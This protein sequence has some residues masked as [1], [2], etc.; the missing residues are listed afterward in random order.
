MNKAVY[1]LR[2][3]VAELRRRRAIR[4]AVVYAGTAFV[5]LQLGEILVE[6]FGLGAWSLR[7]ITL[8]LVLGFPLVV[9]LTWVFDVTEEGL[10]RTGSGEE[11]AA[12]VGPEGEH[13]ISDAVI[14]GL[15][16][17]IAGLL[18]YPRVFPSEEIKSGQAAQTDT[19]K[20]PDRSVAVLPFAN[21]SGTEKARPL[22]RGL[23]DDLLTRLS[24]RPSA[25]G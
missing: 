23:H 11:A 13:F 4:V 7:L 12:E 20:V 24:N 15:L 22:T 17:L 9:G 2:R 1:W 21:Q 14:I 18:L 8:L 25:P 19:A 6:P 5:I 3:F 10:V 16:V